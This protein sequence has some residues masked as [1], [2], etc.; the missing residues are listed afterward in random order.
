MKPHAILTFPQSWHS[1]WTHE[2]ATS[3]ADI[4]EI[5]SRVRKKLSNLFVFFSWRG[6]GEEGGASTI[7]IHLDLTKPKSEPIVYWST[8]KFSPNKLLGHLKEVHKSTLDFGS[9]GG[10]DIEEKMFRRKKKT[11][12]EK[13]L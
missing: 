13:T 2:G 12:L 7:P 3:E 11:F 10:S 6:R 4:L 5:G 9:E 8:I 1:K